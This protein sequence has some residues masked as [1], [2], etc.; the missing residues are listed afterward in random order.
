MRRVLLVIVVLLLAI[1]LVPYGRNHTNPPVTGQ[2]KWDSPETEQLARRACFE[3][4]TNE[5]TWPWYSH[6]A[7]FSWLVQRD[8]DEGREVLDWSTWDGSQAE[9]A[10]ESAEEV[11]EGEMPPWFFLP[12]HPEARLSDAEKER[13]IAGLRKT[14]PPVE[15]EGKV[16]GR[17]DEDAD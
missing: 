17:G 16:G 7:P 3:C 6:V 15:E 9:A 2:P 11:E 8:V 5:T 1:Q 10:G 13:L 4:H 12:L 14:F